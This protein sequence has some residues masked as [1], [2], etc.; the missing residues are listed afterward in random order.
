MNNID[1]IKEYIPK[2]NYDIIVSIMAPI[3]DYQ[4]ITLIDQ[5]VPEDKKKELFEY[6]YNKTDDELLKNTLDVMLHNEYYCLIDYNIT[7]ERSEK[8]FIFNPFEKGDFVKYKDDV[9]L[10]AESKEEYKDSIYRI[11]KNNS[12]SLNNYIHESVI[13]AHSNLLLLG[14]DNDGKYWHCNKHPIF[15]EKV[16]N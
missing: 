8:F 15:L 6:V 1:L 13:D 3:T 9:L 10:V 2:S 11:I 14:I 4:I 7:N 5:C 12:D 16:I